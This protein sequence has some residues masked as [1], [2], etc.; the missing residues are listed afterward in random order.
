ME[1]FYGTNRFATFYKEDTLLK[2]L[3]WQSNRGAGTRLDATFGVQPIRVTPSC[4][5]GWCRRMGG[6]CH[7]QHLPTFQNLPLPVLL[8]PLPPRLEHPF[9]SS[10]AKHTRGSVLPVLGLPGPSA[11]PQHPRGHRHRG[12]EQELEPMRG[13]LWNSALTAAPA[14][15]LPDPL[16]PGQPRGRP[17]SAHTL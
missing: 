12:P 7:H 5:S 1:L 2:H 14:A 17:R 13:T 15:P 16:P 3:N 8:I 9:S 6:S 11:G 10:R 4:G